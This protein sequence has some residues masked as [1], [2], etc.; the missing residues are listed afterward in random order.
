MERNLAASPDGR[1]TVSAE[2][3]N[4]NK[5]AGEALHIRGRNG[6][7]EASQNH[8]LSGSW[9]QPNLLHQCSFTPDGR[10]VM[11]VTTWDTVLT[12]ERYRYSTTL[13]CWNAETGE[14]AA[15]PLPDV[16]ALSPDG[17]IAVFK[18]HAETPVGSKV[19]RANAPASPHYEAR[20]LAT[21]RVWP[22]SELKEESFLLSSGGKWLAANTIGSSTVTIREGQMGHVVNRLVGHT[23]AIVNICFSPDGR[24][25]A[26]TA[27]DNTLRLWDT[28]SGRILLTLPCKEPLDVPVFS[29][30]GLDLVSLGITGRLVVYRKAPEQA[31]AHE[32]LASVAVEFL[33]PLAD[34]GDP[35]EAL[36]VGQR[37]LARDPTIK[38]IVAQQ[39]NATAWRVVDPEAKVKAAPDRIAAAIPA[40]D[41]AVSL[42]NR[43]DPLI[44]DTLAAAYFAN[45][46]ARRAIEIEQEAL[47]LPIADAANRAALL[48][49]M[50]RFKAAGAK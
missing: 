29:P 1:W 48:K 32:D 18:R 31:M 37:L 4:N 10:F 41:R 45:G 40:A 33:R 34:A 42:S 28:E 36:A 14:R 50:S 30:D 23:S 27:N 15:P 21:G 20:D 16:V 38:Q 7:K 3:A 49:N 9:C 5:R 43:R 35:M 25:I 46:N 12:R 39:L 2:Y 11:A 17:R 44:L 26:T 24:R 6:Q 13:Q 22:L 47:Q 8:I 19:S